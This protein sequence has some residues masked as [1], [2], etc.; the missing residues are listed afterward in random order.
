MSPENL[1]SEPEQATDWG[2]TESS[3]FRWTSGQF[4]ARKYELFGNEWLGR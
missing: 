2:G 3:T 4:Q 1:Y